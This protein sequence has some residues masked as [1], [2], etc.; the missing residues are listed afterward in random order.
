[1]SDKSLSIWHSCS[2]ERRGTVHMHKNEILTDVMR[3]VEE[4]TA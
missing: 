2:R 4:N 3:T 1:M